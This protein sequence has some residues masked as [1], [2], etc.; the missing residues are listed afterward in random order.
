[1][2]RKREAGHIESSAC[3]TFISIAAKCR[4]VYLRLLGACRWWIR[5]ELGATRRSRYHG[6]CV[7]LP[8]RC[9]RRGSSRRSSHVRG[10]MADLGMPVSLRVTDESKGE[11]RAWKLILRSYE[12]F[13][14]SWR[15]EKYLYFATLYSCFELPPV[16]DKDRTSYR[17]SAMFDVRHLES[18]LLASRVL[19]LSTVVYAN[20]AIWRSVLSILET[21]SRIVGDTNAEIRVWIRNMYPR[22]IAILLAI[23]DPWLRCLFS[24]DGAQGPLLFTK[25][26]PAFGDVWVLFQLNIEIVA[27]SFQ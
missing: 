9:I 12:I 24:N 15:V 19:L 21:A 14:P 20:R 27:K 6:A 1:M 18:R 17:L 16:I 8:V 7:L 25:R 5:G 23:G 3:E 11:T 13:Y 22:K 2:S 10:A 26:M 4:N